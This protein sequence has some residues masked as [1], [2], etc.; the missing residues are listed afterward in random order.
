M[1]KSKMLKNTMGLSSFWMINKAL[2]KKIGLEETLVLQHLIDMSTLD[3]MGDEFFHTVSKISEETCISERK[4]PTITAKLQELNLIDIVRKG[5]PCK[6]YYKINDESILNLLSS[7]NEIRKSRPTKNGVTSDTKNDVSIRENKRKNKRDNILSTIEKDTQFNSPESSSALFQLDSK[8]NWE[9]ILSLWI[10]EES[11]SVLSAVYK[12]HFLN[13]DRNKQ[14][15]IV[16]FIKTLG[17]DL[18]FMRKIWIS[19]FLKN[20]SD[21]DSLKKDIERKKQFNKLNTH[22]KNMDIATQE[23]LKKSSDGAIDMNQY[24]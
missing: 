14:E 8:H 10:T 23:E 15:G 24:F 18:Q 13:M 6:N 2:T 21:L 3:I 5:V 9:T 4:I 20:G 19:S 11:S 1:K 17:S 7:D 12:K 16:Q 22:S